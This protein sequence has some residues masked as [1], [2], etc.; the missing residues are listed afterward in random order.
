[1]NEARLATA[2]TE[3][4][5]W[6]TSGRDA[7]GAYYSPLSQVNAE[8]VQRLGFAWDY[9]LGTSRGLEASPVVVDGTMF[10]VGNFGRVYAVD[11]A[12]GRQRW[13]YTPDVDAQWLRNACCDAVSRGLA[14]WQGR[15]YAASIDG[16]LFAL[17]ADSG[18]VLWRVDTLIG[19]DKRLPYTTPGAPIIAGNAV[20]I[21]NAGGD[22][23]GV[24]GYVTAY[25]L[26]S[27]KL[28]W[29][30]FT[31]PR[32]PAL[33]PQD[34]PHLAKAISTWDPRHQ[35][36]FGGGG[37]VWDGMAYD[38]KLDLLYFGTGNVSPYDTRADGRKGG[39][40]LYACSIVAV[41]A[42]TGELAWYYQEVPD[43]HWDYDADEKFILTDLDIGG[44][45]RS[46]LLHAPKNGL[47]YAID[48]ATGEVLS[49]QN[50]VFENW[51]L[52]VDAKTFR[53]IPNAAAE[54]SSTPA[55]IW[56]S[57]FGGHSWHPM[58]YSAA[59][60]LVYIPS[61]EMPNVL[62]ETSQRPAGY[63]EGWFTVQGIV[64]GDYDPPRMTT[65]YGKLPALSELQRKSHGPST[66]GRGVLKAWDPVRGKVVWEQPGA[67]VWDGG[68]LSTAGNLVLRGD[69]RGFLNVYSADS[70]RLLRQIDVGTSI[71]AAPISY[72][73]GNEQYVAFMAGYGGGGG[74]LFPH[75]S[76]AYRF[77]NAGRIV[78]L[79]LDGGPVPKP[80][81]LEERP[82][83]MPPAVNDA[84]AKQIAEGEVLYNRYCSRCH[85]F[86]RGLLPDLRRMSPATH[87][88]FYDIV[89]RGAYLP[90]GMARWD[91]V[92]QQRDAEAIHAYLLDQSWAAY[93]GAPGAA[94]KSY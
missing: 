20:V 78:A 58:S 72:S 1:V 25:D 65:L 89:L 88:L 68:I 57:A 9:P 17:A 93:R 21:G 38:A 33:G 16:Y 11:A 45:K 62:I 18:K 42:H 94:T 26:E 55:L 32:D 64:P 36:E 4:G 41:H 6:F 34:Q 69:A 84:G 60:G 53:P 3:P 50:F 37:T 63:T 92:L 82:F 48:R 12:T 8:T 59:T 13:T 40:N 49:A 46:V 51:N 52:G 80:P 31:V 73:V 19:R 7:S 76:A 83:L 27:G 47:F 81:P 14:V 85:V 43:D 15:V 61:I 79:K 70:G 75:E 66:A 67:S 71:M 87:A 90:K 91:D 56:P 23:P 29:R 28:T 5:Q 54:Y 2:A 24:R 44:A 86:G 30:F 77:G 74:F 10:A 22:Y 35:W 39:D